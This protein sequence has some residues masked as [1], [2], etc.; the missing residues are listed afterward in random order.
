MARAEP[1]ARARRLGLCIECTHLPVAEGRNYCPRCLETRSLRWK[2]RAEKLNAYKRVRDTNRKLLAAYGREVQF[3]L[4]HGLEA[5]PPPVL[6]TFV[7]K[8]WGRMWRLIRKPK[9]IRRGRYKY[10]PKPLPKPSESV[11]KCSTNSVVECLSSGP[12][13]EG[14]AH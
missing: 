1:V 9:K 8:P 4:D 3:A 13:S 12:S 7:P 5:P 14:E 10:T 6:V 2:R 11:I